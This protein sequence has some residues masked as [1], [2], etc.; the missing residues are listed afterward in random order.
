M[1]V[2]TMKFRCASWS[3][4]CEGKYLIILRACP[5]NFVSNL[6][7]CVKCLKDGLVGMRRKLN[8]ISQRVEE[9]LAE[10]GEHALKVTSEG[11]IGMTVQWVQALAVEAFLMGCS[12]KRSALFN[13][14]RAADD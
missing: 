14:Q 4:R 11:Y 2:M 9:S 7:H 13:R 8:C 12:D 1:I 3:R 10:C 5:R 6:I